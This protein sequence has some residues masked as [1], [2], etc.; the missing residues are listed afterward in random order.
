MAK[1]KSRSSAQPKRRGAVSLASPAEFGEA[2]RAARVARGLT[3]EDVA[4]AAKVSRLFVYHAENGKSTMRMDKVL[5]LM[6][7]VGLAAVA[8]P[9]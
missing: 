7:A 9:T 6:K 5:D 2:L 8:V 3:Q 1:S 4:S